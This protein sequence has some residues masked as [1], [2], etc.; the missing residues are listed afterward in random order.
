MVDSSSLDIKFGR[1]KEPLDKKFLNLYKKAIKGEFL[2][3][4]AK[5]KIEGIKPF[6][7]FK[8]TISDAFKEYFCDKLKAG[9]VSL[10]VYQQNDEFIM[11]DNYNSYCMY[12]Q[13]DFKEVFAQY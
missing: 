1:D 4:I 12:L 10:Y 6:S 3:Y 2:C 11:S 9:G 7:D 5:I 8:P 13:N